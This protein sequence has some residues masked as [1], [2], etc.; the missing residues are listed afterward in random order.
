MSYEKRGVS[1]QKSEV[2]EAIKHLDNG[3]YP[4][5]FCKILPDIASGDEAFCT[6]LHAD[7]AGT[8]SS[9]AYLYWKETGDLSVWKGIVQDAIVM[10]TDDMACV[11]AVNNIILS[12]TIGRNK[13]IIPGEVLNALIEG[14]QEFIENMA[15]NGVE[16]VLA[17]GET[18]DV[19]DIVRTLDVGF[20][21]FA[22][23][24][25]SQ[26]I[27]IKP[28][29]GDVII[30]LASYGQAS[31]EREY[32]SGIGSNGLTFAR[33]ELFNHNYASKYPE[34]FAPQTDIEYIYTGKYLVTD[35]ENDTQLP[36]G[37]LA[38]SPTR[39]FL[40]VIKTLLS[41]HFE[42]IHGIVH[43]TGGGYSKSKKFQNGLDTVKDNLLPIPPIF[44]R[45]QEIKNTDWKEMF[46]VFN[47]GCRLE[48]YVPA[49]VGK[50]IIAIAQSYNIHSEQI[51]YVT[52]GSGDVTIKY[53][54]TVIA[55]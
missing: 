6:L 22:R 45:I 50:E 1:S 3:I 34:T 29:E 41:E 40:P 31:Y 51:G 5:A 4:N 32:N 12:S 23:M 54:D 48:V 47:C 46:Q 33:H 37:K 43:N 27:D 21:A 20:T 11:G 28:Q 14:T 44:S 17:G 53:K 9:L 39:T 19:G 49:S 2:H 36:F 30:G 7:T 26:V 16:L 42:S 38:L 8:K 18:A 10:N 55:Y 35:I 25:R 13:H 52:K 24:F 15:K